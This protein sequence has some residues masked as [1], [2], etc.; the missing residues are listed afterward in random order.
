LRAKMEST[1]FPSDF[2]FLT[3]QPYLTLYSENDMVEL[4]KMNVGAGRLRPRKRE[5]L[6]NLTVEQK[7]QRRKLKNR[8]AAQCARDRKKKALANLESNAALLQTENLYLR[9]SLK[10]L[11]ITNRQLREENERLQALLAS[12]G[13]SSSCGAEYVVAAVESA[14][15][16]NAPLPKAQV[17]RCILM[18]RSLFCLIPTMGHSLKPSNQ[19]L[20]QRQHQGCVEI[21]ALCEEDACFF[22][23]NDCQR[24]FQD[25][26]SPCSQDSV[27]PCSPAAVATIMHDHCYLSS[28]NAKTMHAA[29]LDMSSALSPLS[30]ADSRD[31]AL[32]NSLAPSDSSVEQSSISPISF[33]A[34]CE[35]DMVDW[36][37]IFATGQDDFGLQN[38]DT[39]GKEW[40]DDS[41]NLDCDNFSFDNILF[42]N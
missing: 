1:L 25:S 31:F 38:N 27:S 19:F 16:I 34:Q 36:T 39:A 13:E 23:E 14:E 42:C 21:Q 17:A 18:L 10:E 41:L 20:I 7:L 4:S 3:N 29:A 9:T 15:F 28:C 12:K 24:E 33:D 11:E 35:L 26:V 22:G 2:V 37:Q 30:F 40:T 5:C 6:N 8:V 32:L